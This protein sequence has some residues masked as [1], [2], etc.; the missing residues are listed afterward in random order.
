MARHSKKRRLNK[1]LVSFTAL[2][3]LVI[4]AGSLAYWHY[5]NKPSQEVIP[6]SPSSSAAKPKSSPDTQT[7][8]NPAAS[9]KQIAASNSSGVSS[10]TQNPTNGT[11]QPPIVPNGNFVSNHGSPAYPAGAETSACNTTPGASCYIE[12]VN[13]N[14]TKTL[15]SQITDSNGSTIWNWDASSFPSGTW[16]ITA[17]AT[18]NGQ[19]K[20][21]SD[22][23]SLVIQ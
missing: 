22:A 11:G 6:S 16:Q 15:D 7:A 23:T 12:F 2:A 10:N 3:L 20:T 8:N 4:T 18:L 21:A 9:D 17:V 19:T 1:K 13:G 5:Q 14:D